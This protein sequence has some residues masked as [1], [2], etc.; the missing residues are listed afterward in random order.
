M[1]IGQVAFNSSTQTF[2]IN[3]VVSHAYLLVVTVMTFILHTW[4][5]GRVSGARKTYNV[6]LP[7]LYEAADE[8]GGAKSPFNNYQRGHMVNS[9]VLNF[10]RTWLKILR[11]ST[12]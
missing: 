11:L 12:L 3:F 2:S 5:G 8:K 1:N 9:L 10:F 6:Q 4:L 7:H